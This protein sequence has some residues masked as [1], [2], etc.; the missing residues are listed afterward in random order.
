M[1]AETPLFSVCVI[2]RSRLVKN[3]LLSF[4]SASTERQTHLLALSYYSFPNYFRL[5]RGFVGPTVGMPA[6]LHDSQSHGPRRHGRDGV[7]RSLRD[8][9]VWCCGGD[10][11]CTAARRHHF[12]LSKCLHLGLLCV[13]IDPL[14]AGLFDYELYLQKRKC[15]I[16]VFLVSW[17][18]LQTEPFCLLVSDNAFLFQT[19]LRFVLPFMNDSYVPNRFFIHYR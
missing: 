19:F 13:P 16:V 10:R 11:Q 1:T 8:C 7:C 6:P 18:D 2:V 15:I 5:N 3:V 17:F 14:C 9:V 4:L 12:L